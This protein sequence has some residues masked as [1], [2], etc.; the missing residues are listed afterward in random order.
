MSGGGKQGSA[1]GDIDR[2]RQ[3]LNGLIHSNQQLSDNIKALSTAPRHAATSSIDSFCPTIPFTP[4]PS[5]P[6]SAMHGA[7]IVSSPARSLAAGI[8]MHP[9]SVSTSD[10]PLSTAVAEAAATPSHPPSPAASRAAHRRSSALRRLQTAEHALTSAAALTAEVERLS[11]R[12][13]DRQQQS[14][15]SQ[16]PTS[17]SHTAALPAT[18]DTSSSSRPQQ[19]ST[20]PQW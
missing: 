17:P 11:P 9:S 8:P 6:V 15:S 14:Q 19:H 16:R 13:A 7:S 3:A 20:T 1:V 2:I 10:A 5:A 18:T 12:S 4:S